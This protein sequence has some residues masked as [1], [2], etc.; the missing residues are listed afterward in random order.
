MYLHYYS[1]C[2][3]H[4]AFPECCT[5]KYPLIS[6]ASF[7]NHFP[8]LGRESFKISNRASS[9]QLNGVSPGTCQVIQSCWKQFCQYVNLDFRCLVVSLIV[10]L[11]LQSRKYFVW[12][13]TCTGFL[14]LVPVLI[15]Y[16]ASLKFVAVP[17]VLFFIACCGPVPMYQNYVKIFQGRVR[18]K[19]IWKKYCSVQLG[20][21]T[22][23]LSGL[24]VHLNHCFEIKGVS[25]NPT[26]QCLRKIMHMPCWR[27]AES[28]VLK[29]LEDQCSH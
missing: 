6:N 7:N 19:E 10:C 3:Q 21:V 8:S 23:V 24:S 1:V 27:H 4:F 2:V 22:S 25:H 17:S 20:S 29:L 9:R 13:Y 11:C 28:L 18:G 14:I 5:E 15:R 16:P 12:E 26:V